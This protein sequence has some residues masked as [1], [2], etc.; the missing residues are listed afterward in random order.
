MTKIWRFAD[1]KVA[2]K[3]AE[4]FC[5]EE[6]TVVRKTTVMICET[7]SETIHWLREQAE[8]YNAGYLLALELDIK[9]V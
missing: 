3:F 8:A 7:D 6:L 1:A 9:G 2:N 5:S 4:R